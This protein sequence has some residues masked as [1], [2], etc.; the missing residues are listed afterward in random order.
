MDAADVFSDVGKSD[1]SENKK[2]DTGNMMNKVLIYHT[3]TNEAYTPLF[4]GE[5][6]AYSA[7]MTADNNYNVNA[8]GHVMAENIERNGIGVVHDM[9]N[10]IAEVYSE[11]YDVSLE[12]MKENIEKDDH[13]NVL[14]DV[15]RDSVDDKE[16]AAKD[17]TVYEGREYAR[18]LFVVG[19]GE[20]YSGDE[21]PDW[22]A[23]SA[24]A[25][26]ISDALNEKIPG[27][28]KGIMLKK[29]RYNQHLTNKSLLIEVGYD[30]NTLMQAVNTAA[31][32][33]ETI[34]EILE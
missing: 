3:H 23:N 18:V 1:I 14:I 6:L 15:H 9:R 30:A 19:K 21:R 7:Y 25:Q 24:F 4:E 22:E 29:G 13:L 27:I 20:E 10:N 31:V 33:G 11:S 26:S 34:A 28:S 12:T 8:V 17:I 2:E 16:F 5:Y 32:V